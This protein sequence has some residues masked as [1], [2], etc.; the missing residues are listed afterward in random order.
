MKLK[1]YE[2]G[3]EKEAIALV[4][5]DLG[6]EAFIVNM[7]TIHPR[8]IK[9][10]FKKPSVEVT[11]AYDEAPYSGEKGQKYELDFIVEEPPLTNEEFIEETKRLLGQGNGN[12]EEVPH[13]GTD[14]KDLK[15]KEQA[16]TIKE[17]QEKLESTEQILQKVISELKIN[18][19]VV[20]DINRRYEN[21]MLQVFYESLTAQGVTEEIA[22]GILEEINSVG[23]T[24]DLDINLIVKV[25]YNSILG[26]LKY[27]KPLK[28]PGKPR[29]MTFIGPTGVGKTTTIAKLSSNFILNDEMN[30]G[31]ITSDTYRI[32]AI[33]QLKT[34]AEILDIEVRVV[35]DNLE[36][37]DNVVFMGRDNDVI[38]IDTAGRSHRNAET[39]LELKE[40]LEYV[41]DSEKYLVLSLTTKYDDL[42]NII[43]A[44]KDVS[45]FSII[46]T[47]LDETSRIGNILNVCYTTGK[48][49][50]Y[51]TDGQSVPDDIQEM[52]PERVTKMLLGLGGN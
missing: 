47:K 44:Y 52:D 45:D 31:L 43:E 23:A 38:I 48:K 17:L 40:L 7:K 12:E 6:E 51:L 8:G 2:A 42:V 49:V 27:D 16:D 10:F 3:T 18:S 25:I 35:Y 41:G 33:E 30:V 26:H 24:S 22:Q 14:S 21:P 13:S 32:A 50:A 9:A 28:I 46:F 5:Q 19:K 34:Y 20:N 4:R 39:L 29:V 1:K 36:I 37:I 15:I 11:A